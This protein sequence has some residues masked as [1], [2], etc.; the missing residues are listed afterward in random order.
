MFL[1]SS[2]IY[3]PDGRSSFQRRIGA[4]PGNRYLPT[5]KNTA[6]LKRSHTIMLKNIYTVTSRQFAHNT[7]SNKNKAHPIHTPNQNPTEHY[8]EIIQS[9]T[10]SLLFI[11]GLDI[12]K[13]W[14]HALIQAVSLQNRTALPGRC[15]SYE[16]SLRKRL[17][18][19][20]IR[21]FGCE[22]LSWKRT[23]ETN[24]VIGL[25]CY[26]RGL[27]CYVRGLRWLG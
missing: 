18:L 1:P 19:S 9:K 27:R 23:K 14:E 10:R 26:V 17:D 2:S 20:H 16:L 11:S 13:F 6:L 3:L 7:A 5:S 12:D 25:G 8:M 21:I 22:A 15:T 4:S 24:Y